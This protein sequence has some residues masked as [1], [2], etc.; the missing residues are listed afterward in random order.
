MH[1]DFDYKIR[2]PQQLDYVVSRPRLVERLRS[3]VSRRL[4][5]IT[6]P[7]GYGKTTLLVEFAHEHQQPVAWYSLDQYDVDPWQFLA[8]LAAAVEYVFPGST[9]ATTAL[10]TSGGSPTLDATAAALLREIY[11]IGQEFV[12][13]IDDWH[14]VDHI[15]DISRF[16]TTLLVRCQNC[17]VILASRLYPG[18]PDVMLLAARRQ[19]AGLDETLLRFTPPEVAAVLSLELNR[20]VTLNR[21]AVLAEQAN[22]WIA[23]I[24]L[25][26]QTDA[27]AHS[28]VID[29]GAERQIYR[30][31][32]EQVLD[33]QPA[34]LRAFMVESSLLDE[35]VADR[36]NVLLGRDDSLAMIEAV[37]RCRNFILEISP[38]TFRY[39]QLFREFLQDHFRASDPAHFWAT[40]RRIAEH[41]SREKRWAQAFDAYLLA[42]D[43]SGACETL[44]L[45]GEETYTLG[46]LETLERWFSLL[47]LETLDA[48]LIALK[49]RVALNRGQIHE[50]DTLADLAQQRMLP[51][52]T[53]VVW[54]LRAQI[55]R[56]AGR[57][58]LAIEYG[59]RAL[60]GAS[61]PARQATALYVLAISEL[62][63]G[64]AER[65]IEL[66]RQALT[67]EQQRGDLYAVALIQQDL[68]VCYHEAG[69]LAAAAEG[70]SRADA[71]WSISGNIGR[72][73]L[74]LNSRGLAEHFSGKYREAYSTFSQAL[75]YAQESGAALHQAAV[76]ASLGD[77]YSDL[78]LYDQAHEVYNEASQ[79]GGTAYIMSY[80]E[81]ANIRLLVRQRR[82]EVADA[83]I[84][85]L[86]PATAGQH[87]STIARMRARIALSAANRAEATTFAQQAI[88]AAGNKASADL[89]LAYLTQAHVKTY[90]PAEPVD[91]IAALQQACAIAERLGSDAFLIA[92]AATMP[93]L[94]SY[95][96]TVGWPASIVWR[97]HQ[98]GLH[99]LGQML[100]SNDARPLLTVR[101]LGSEQ[102]MVNGQAVEI[103]WARAREVLYYLLARP[104]GA[105]IDALRDA[106]WPDLTAEQSRGALKTAVY[107]LRKALPSDMIILQGRQTYHLD[108]GRVRIDYDVDRFFELTS[109]ADP[110]RLREAIDL[111]QG[112]FLPSSENAWSAGLR[113]FLEQSYLS[114]ILR[115]AG[116]LERGGAFNDALAL[117]RRLLVTDPLNEAAHGAIMRCQIALNNRAA[118]IEQ[119]H[120][121]RRALNAELGLDLA[122][123][124]E[125]EQLYQ[126]I[127][128]T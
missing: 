95:A 119:Y 111:Y 31:L 3:V 94:L 38:G 73:A 33:Q 91:V 120:I 44:R 51:S 24:L 53:T 115:A 13:V 122:S 14:L 57:Y 4:I 108:R 101:S 62:R 42:N 64:N 96:Q 65:A 7:A 1:V 16:I 125:A 82:Y 17:H 23:G 109:E 67:I 104:A 28:L 50:A 99:L 74:T 39:H 83:S 89:A 126:Q 68:G 106:I 102:I 60:S 75:H 70:Y 27:S 97:D 9:P 100:S 63:A 86:V 20:E 47:P 114:A 59:K 52:E 84:A 22:G 110:E 10:L 88:A 92:D 18:L 113:A 35:L 81:V 25:V 93:G 41:Y 85:H 112:P 128:N 121:L 118:A 32:A 123:T 11:A 116:L 12:L 19:M 72:R 127:L 98:Q 80:L 40:A 58:E 46:R 124:S 29:K 77:L 90:D 54:L 87:E 15:T 78:G 45:G 79:A 30:F 26:A 71:Y 5:T 36:C 49:A 55:E 37:V 6:A 103:G 2:I 8:Y 76:L 61:D 105:G 34:A 56:I 117:Y 43:T 21:A 48:P 69:Q 107:Q 66:L